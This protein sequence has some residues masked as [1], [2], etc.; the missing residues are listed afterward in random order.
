MDG[1]HARNI[2]CSYTQGSAFAFV[3][4]CTLEHDNPDVHVGQEAVIE[5][6]LIAIFAQGHCRYFQFAALAR[7]ARQVDERPDR[8]L[9]AAGG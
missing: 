6:L 1:L 4:D 8:R 2:L 5:Q 3:G 9:E 7:P